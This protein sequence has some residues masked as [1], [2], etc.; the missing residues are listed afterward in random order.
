MVV[1]EFQIFLFEIHFKKHFYLTMDT[2]IIKSINTKRNVC[3]KENPLENLYYN[4]GNFGYLH[5]QKYNTFI[6]SFHDSM[7]RIAILTFSNNSLQHSE[8]FKSRCSAFRC[9]CCCCWWWWLFWWF[10][11]FAD[12]LINL[13]WNEQWRHILRVSL[14]SI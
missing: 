11:C 10:G 9:C 7:R 4:C 13:I 8:R 5:N 3:P 1:C 2:H 12:S 14:H 6:Y